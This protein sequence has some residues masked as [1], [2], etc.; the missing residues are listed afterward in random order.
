MG[1]AASLWSVGSHVQIA[2]VG[3]SA[4]FRD[5]ESLLQSRETACNAVGRPW[6]APEKGQQRREWCTDGVA[7][8]TWE[9][10]H[11]GRDRS[12]RGVQVD[13][14]GVCYGKCLLRREEEI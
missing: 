2:F 5:G 14:T 8:S 10:P 11:K 7:L 13:C 4:D 6:G 12:E 9:R 3:S 1:T